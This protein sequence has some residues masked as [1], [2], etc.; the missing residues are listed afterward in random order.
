MITLIGAQ[1][2]GKNTILHLIRKIIGEENFFEC[3]DPCRDVWGSFN[4]K[5]K[6]CFLVNLDELSKKDVIEYIG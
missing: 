1:G 4:S 3:E 6:D 2:C 5:M